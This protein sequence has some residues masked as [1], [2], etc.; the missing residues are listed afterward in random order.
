MGTYYRRQSRLRSYSGRRHSTNKL[1]QSS[2]PSGSEAEAVVEAEAM[3]ETKTAGN[4]PGG[5]TTNQ[6]TQ[7]PVASQ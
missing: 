7:S 2:P 6:W 5:A 3:E 1:R 4:V